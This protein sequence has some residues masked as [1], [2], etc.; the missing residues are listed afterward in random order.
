MLVLT[1]RDGDSIWLNDDIEI[2]LL[3]SR[4]GQAKLAI[5]APDHV[6]IWRDKIYKRIQ[7]Q[8]QKLVDAENNCGL[9]NGNR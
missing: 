1:S 4:N 2:K 5:K 9:V 6:E 3:E 7:G 8:R